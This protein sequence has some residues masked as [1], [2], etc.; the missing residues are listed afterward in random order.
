[1]KLSGDGHVFTFSKIE[2]Q[3]IV[4]RQI[5]LHHGKVFF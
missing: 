1:M 4:N 5:V 3:V 2:I